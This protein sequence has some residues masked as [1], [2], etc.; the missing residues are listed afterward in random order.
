MK[1]NENMSF[2]NKIEFYFKNFQSSMRSALKNK[3]TMRIHETCIVKF[4]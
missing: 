4:I 1:K 3:N 2:A